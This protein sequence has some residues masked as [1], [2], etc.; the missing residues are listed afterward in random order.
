MNH[1]A[2]FYC[3]SDNFFLCL[4]HFLFIRIHDYYTFML[5]E[6]NVVFNINK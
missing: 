4:W 1:L 2:H 5:I 6:W 3:F